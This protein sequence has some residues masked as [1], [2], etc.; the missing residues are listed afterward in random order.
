MVGEVLGGV[1]GWEWVRGKGGVGES[2][3]KN[4]VLQNLTKCEL[5]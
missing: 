3:C 4:M 5:A 2:R 1:E